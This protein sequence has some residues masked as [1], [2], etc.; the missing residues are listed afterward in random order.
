[1]GVSVKG[2]R[3]RGLSILQTITSERDARRSEIDVTGPVRIHTLGRFSVQLHRQ[4]VTGTAKPRYQRSLELLQALI[5]L[6]GRDVH[7]ELL[8]QAL[9]PDADGDNAQNAFDVTLYRLR[10]LFNID[11]LFLINNRRLTLNGELVWVDVWTFERLVNHAERLLDRISEPA[12]ARQLSRSEE[13]LLNLYQG[14]FLEREAFRPWTLSLRERL[15]SKLLRHMNEAGPAWEKAGEWDT[16][17]RFYRKGLEIDPLI[18]TLY[19]RLMICFR[20]TGRTAEALATYQRCRAILSEQLQIQPSR[21]TRELYNS[22]R[23]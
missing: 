12:I 17:I 9:W 2:G 13:R 1:M 16:A 23:T 10:Q 7:A 15:R 18:E 4:P 20:Q 21:E 3:V 5:A 14:S 11:D 22:L 19:R 6:G 8:A